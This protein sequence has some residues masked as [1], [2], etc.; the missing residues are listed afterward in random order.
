MKTKLQ[1]NASASNIQ[2]AIRK[3]TSSEITEIEY[4]K[5]G[6]NIYVDDVFVDSTSGN[7]NVLTTTDRIRVMGLVRIPQGLC[8]TFEVAVQ[9]YT[10]TPNGLKD[11]PLMSRNSYYSL[12]NKRAAAFTEPIAVDP[13]KEGFEGYWIC[14]LPI[15]AIQF[16]DEIWKS[17]E[18]VV[19][20]LAEPLLYTDGIPLRAGRQ[21][22][23]QI[24][25]K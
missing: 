18:Q 8:R 10:Q 6:L 9:F 11:K 7:R 2:E 1:E 23:F 5:L 12:M 14:D 3:S 15:S 19:K 13:E 16:P 25:G 17:D 24:S 4:S 20:L 22:E 21:V